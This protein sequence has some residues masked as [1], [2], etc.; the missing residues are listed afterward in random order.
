MASQ[1]MGSLDQH[2]YAASKPKTEKTA[3]KV[4]EYT[5]VEGDYLE[6]IAQDHKTTWQRLFNKNVD[7]VNPHLVF[8]GQKITIPAANEKLAERNVE[9]P[10]GGSNVEVVPSTAPPAQAA[11]E[12]PR[13]PE[14]PVLSRILGTKEDWM[15]QAGIP[16]SEWWAVDSIVSR[17]S[18]WNPNAVNASSGACGLGQQLPCG[19]WA[20]AWNDPVAALRAQHGYVVERYGS[21]SGAVAFWNANHWY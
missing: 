4:V 2:V 13:A 16:Q 9:V 12:A 14:A 3:P 18:G 8:V 15:A 10:E 19:K 5:I 6:K 11:P 17:E 1:S 20:G 7:I 21:Y